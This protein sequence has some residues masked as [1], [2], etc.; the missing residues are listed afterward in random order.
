[1]QVFLADKSF[2]G[3][4]GLAMTDTMRV[5]IAG[6]ACLLVAN[7]T[8][9]P[10]PWVREILVYPDTFL[11]DREYVDEAG[12]RS[13]GREALAGESWDEGRVNISWQDVVEDARCADGVNVVVHEFAHQLDHASGV[14]NGA[15]VLRGNTAQWS[16]VMADE[17]AR[18][19]ERVDNDDTEDS[20]IDP[21][22][23][24]D[25]GEFFA[26]VFE[27]FIETPRA[28]ARDHPAMYSLLCSY[29]RLDPA[30]W[31]PDHTSVRS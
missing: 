21:Y 7:L 1:M 29:S 19:A 17:Y 18:L 3:C 16:S 23:A 12:V 11:V 6:H 15:P 10:F 30:A 27:A 4:N 13:V 2:V 8:D 24:T 14:V 5:T 22:G 20:V 28:L 26:V 25:P 9:D 31:G